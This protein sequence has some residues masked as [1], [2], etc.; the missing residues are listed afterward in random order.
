M[1]RIRPGGWR[2]RNP[3][4]RIHGTSLGTIGGIGCIIHNASWMAGI[5]ATAAAA[6]IA[7]L[8]RKIIAASTAPASASSG[9]AVLSNRRLLIASGK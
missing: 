7:A 5:K 1:A 2:W 3:A 8:R 4:A 6:I 9:M